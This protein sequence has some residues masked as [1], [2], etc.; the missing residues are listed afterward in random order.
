MKQIQRF[1][2]LTLSLAIILCLCAC[3]SGAA[4]ADSAP[5]AQSAPEAPETAESPE[6]AP[7]EAVPEAP[8]PEEAP[9]PAAFPTEGSYTMFGML[10][11][12]FL[13]SAD[14]L[15]RSSELT[16]SADGTGSLVLATPADSQ[17]LA[18]TE[19]T[20]ADGTLSLTM[21]D[22]SAASGVIRDGVAEVDLFGTGDSTIY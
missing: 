17:T 1:L 11:D 16:L 14:A 15:E 19:W 6:T 12:G 13:V 5:Q 4:P 3:G 2:A 18:I 8:A 7:A 21:E 9:E 20:A 22:G 10:A